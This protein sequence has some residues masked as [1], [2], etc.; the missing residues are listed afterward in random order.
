MLKNLLGRALEEF[1][2]SSIETAAVYYELG[3]SLFLDS[4]TINGSIVDADAVEEALEYMAKSCA[5]LYAHADDGMDNKSK[6]SDNNTTRRT[7]SANYSQW[8]KDHA[9]DATSITIPS[10]KPRLFCLHGAQS[11]AP[12]RVRFRVGEGVGSVGVGA[13]SCT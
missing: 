5:I 4:S 12:Y 8:A 11:V 2:D 10:E 9:E 7:G 1:G 3:H 6:H 13:W